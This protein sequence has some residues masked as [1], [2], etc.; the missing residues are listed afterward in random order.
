MEN[1]AT[2]PAAFFLQSTPDSVGAPERG[3]ADW[4]SLAIQG[5]E[6]LGLAYDLVRLGGWH[7]N[8]EHQQIT[9]MGYH[10]QLFGL[11]PGTLPNTY[12]GFLAR[13]HPED[14][15]PVQREIERCLSCCEDYRQ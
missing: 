7:W 12:E 4:R 15:E 1:R 14:R 2:H 11:D 8:I 6:Q 9:R 5:Q 10:E 13:L 3:L